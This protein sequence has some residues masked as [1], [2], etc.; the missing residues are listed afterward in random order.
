MEVTPGSSDDGK[1]L[2]SLL[3]QTQANGISVTEIIG[4]TAYSGKD[5]LAEMKKE[6]IQPVVPLNPIV[7]HGGERQ[8]GFEYNKDADFMVCPAGQHSTRKAM[9]GSKQS[10]KSRSLVFY[11]DV[12]KCKA[13]PLSEGCYKRGSKSKTYS[14]RIIAEH[15]KEQIEFELSDTFKERIKRRPIIEHKNAEMKRFHGMATAKYRGL[16]RMR[17]QAY[18]T[19]FVVNVKR[20]VKLVEHKQPALE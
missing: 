8:E 17:I 6:T 7:H 9:Q 14:V 2:S 3:S 5:N 19:A 4:D 18:L 20:M 10:G 13:C 11:F 1:Q 12:E 15:F 16:F